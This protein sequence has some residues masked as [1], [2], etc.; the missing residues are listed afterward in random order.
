MRM[1]RACKKQLQCRLCDHVDS[2]LVR[3]T[4]VTRHNCRTTSSLCGVRRGR[5]LRASVHVGEVEGSGVGFESVASHA[6]STLK[7]HI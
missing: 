7:A 2:A 6:R 4:T 3:A 5:G 1:V